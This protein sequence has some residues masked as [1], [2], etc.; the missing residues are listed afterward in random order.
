MTAIDADQLAKAKSSAMASLAMR[1]HSVLELQQKLA[2]KNYTAAVIDQVVTELQQQ[3]F[4]SNERFAEVYWR[5][6]AEKGFGPV[7]I[8]L[9]LQQKGL[10]E[11]IIEH[12]LVAAEVD[13]EALIQRVYQKQY[14]NKPCRDLKD[15]ARRQGFLFRRGFPADAIRS[16]LD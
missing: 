5:Q 16:V 10:E 4:L 13:F 6:R 1:E 2:R 3:N 11:A 12:G 8:S 9:E 15:K 7:K 14:H